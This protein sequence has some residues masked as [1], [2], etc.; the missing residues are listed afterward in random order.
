MN[1]IKCLSDDDELVYVQY[2]TMIIIKLNLLRVGLGLC[3]ERPYRDFDLRIGHDGLSTLY[4]TFPRRRD[5]T[6][7]S[8]IFSYVNLEQRTAFPSESSAFSSAHTF[9]R[10]PRHEYFAR[11]EGYLIFYDSIGVPTCTKYSVYEVRDFR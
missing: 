5:D 2:F 11:R 8:K 10:T 3:A 7:N 1:I 4:D 9:F 6:A